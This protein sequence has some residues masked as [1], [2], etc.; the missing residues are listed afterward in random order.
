MFPFD[1]VIMQM[2]L[3]ILTLLSVLIYVFCLSQISPYAQAGRKI[4]LAVPIGY[5]LGN[6]ILKAVYKGWQVL[7]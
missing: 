5:Q 7:P 4:V 2:W 3:L 6:N 1:D